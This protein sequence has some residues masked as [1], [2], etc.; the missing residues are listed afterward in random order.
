MQAYGA[1][2]AD[3]DLAIAVRPEFAEAHGN[4][5][6]ALREIGRHR[7]ALEAFDRALALKPDYDEAYNNRGMR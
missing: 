5:G 3:Y 1:A 4:R 6:N 7:E 2:L